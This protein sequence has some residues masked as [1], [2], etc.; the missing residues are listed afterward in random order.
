MPQRPCFACPSEREGGVSL[1]D[2]GRPGHSLDRYVPLA[3][4]GR[5]ASPS[6]DDPRVSSSS[7]PSRIE[8]LANSESKGTRTS[9][10]QSLACRK[11][12]DY[13]QPGSQFP[14]CAWQRADPF[15][16]A[17]RNGSGSGIRVRLSG[18]SCEIQRPQRR[19]RRPQRT[20]CRAAR[21]HAACCKVRLCLQPHQARLRPCSSRLASDQVFG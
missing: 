20:L 16:E 18:P 10:R 12:I 11:P 4:T 3:R 17:A 7:L 5:A 1:V 9:R 8:R 21:T 14:T 15:G 19:A 2:A 6:A 13:R